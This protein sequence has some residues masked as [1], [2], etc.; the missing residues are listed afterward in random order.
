[1]TRTRANIRT[2]ILHIAKR[3]LHLTDSHKLSSLNFCPLGFPGKIVKPQWQRFPKLIC[4]SLSITW[5]CP[6]VR[7]DLSVSSTSNAV[8]P[9]ALA[10]V[11]LYVRVVFTQAQPCS[12][13]YTDKISHFLQEHYSTA[14]HPAKKG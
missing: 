9:W 6:E 1:M 10:T 3:K 12:Q 5:E 2:Y 4:I 8:K 14:S 7:Q 11:G 13:N